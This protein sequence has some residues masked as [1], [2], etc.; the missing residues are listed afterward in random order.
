MKT[1]RCFVIA[2]LMLLVQWGLVFGP[3]TRAAVVKEFQQTPGNIFLSFALGA[4]TTAEAVPPHA[5]N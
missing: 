1:R 3:V 2:G 5:A 4:G